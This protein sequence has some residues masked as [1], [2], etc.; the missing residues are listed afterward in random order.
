MP[1][2][3]AALILLLVGFGFYKAR[4]RQQNT[5]ADSSFMESASPDSFFGSSGGQNVDTYKSQTPGSLLPAGPSQFEAEDEVD[6]LA[7]AEV[8]L[9]YGRDVQAEEILKD[10]LLAQPERLAVHQK[11]LSIYAK[12]KDASAYSTIATLAN[13]LTQGTGPEWTQICKTGLTLE[14]GNALY[15]AGGP[16]P[17]LPASVPQASLPPASSQAKADA[18]P[19][20]AAEANQGNELDL[21]MDLDLDFSVDQPVSSADRQPSG[22][23]SFDLDSLSLD[24]DNS[25]A[26][27]AQAA[28]GVS[29][30]TLEAKLALAEEFR[31]NGDDDGARELIKQV[32][33][34]A[35]GVTKAKAQQALGQI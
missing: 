27:A 35:D 28:T 31:A 9:A 26:T 29:A 14:P 8:Y 21:D 2:G 25:N 34:E 15:L 5:L 13:A 17:S 32:I 6:P 3:A 12:R 20:A 24:L 4:Q 19:V 7:Q 33:S 22:M 23:M 30:E 10:A 1:A 16:S 18:A 11:L